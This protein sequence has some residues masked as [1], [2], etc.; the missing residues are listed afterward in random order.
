MRSPPAPAAIEA[1]AVDPPGLWLLACTVTG[2]VRRWL[3][4]GLLAA[5]VA[6]SAGHTTTTTPD[7]A[8]SGPCAG[9]A[10]ARYSHVIVVVMENHGFSQIQGHSPYLNGLAMQCGLAAG[11]R[12]TRHPSLPN[13][14]AMTGGSTFAIT[15]DCTS[16]DVNA[17]S[18]FGQV[19]GS[20]RAYEESIP[21]TGYLGAQSGRYYKK[22]NPAAY[23]LPLRTQYATRAVGMTAF[24]NALSAGTLPRYSF[25]TP[26][27]CDDEHDCSIATGD[28]WLKTWVGRILAGPN[29]A[30][31]NTLLVVT[32]D[33]DSGSEGNRVYTVVVAPS[34][35]PGTVS[36]A[37][38]THYSLLRTAEA[39]MGVPLL[40]S[41]G[42]ASSMQAA[43]H[44]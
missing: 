20:W 9:T 19:S 31:K 18:V 33:E 37:A 30:A 41:A 34:V 6:L 13:Y 44:L 28:G 7:A 4:L 36:A 22:H 39:E 42:S 8:A 12:A 32:Y 15:N 35:V 29:Y 3:V 17:S 5:L 40:R 11:Y 23:Y 27:I 16:C 38:F 2:M 25:V 43:F 21:S 24:A 26:N 1:R 14:L 10:T